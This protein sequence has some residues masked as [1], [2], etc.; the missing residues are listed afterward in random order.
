MSFSVHMLI[1]IY[2][3]IELYLFFELCVCF[4]IPTRPVTG[5][6]GS[7]VDDSS[8]KIL[9]SLDLTGL[10]LYIIILCYCFFLLMSYHLGKSDK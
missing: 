3:L 2:S 8:L 7:C 4:E 6:N 9:F 1:L 10:V 5:L